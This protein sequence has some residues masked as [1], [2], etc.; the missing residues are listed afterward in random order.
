[1]AA[2][3]R[4]TRGSRAS[5]MRQEQADETGSNGHRG[6][7][8]VWA[9]WHRGSCFGNHN[10]G[11]QSHG[12]Q[13][14]WDTAALGHSVSQGHGIFVLDSQGCSNCISMVLLPQL[15]G[16]G[17]G[18]QPV[19]GAGPRGCSW[20]PALSGCQPHPLPGLSLTSPPLASPPSP[21][22]PPW[23]LPAWLLLRSS[24]AQVKPTP[25]CAG[26]PRTP[27][28]PHPPGAT[29]PG[30][31]PGRAPSP[32]VVGAAAASAREQVHFLEPCSCCAA[33]LAHACCQ[34]RGRATA[35]GTGH[36]ALPAA[37]GHGR[38]PKAGSCL[39]PGHLAPAAGPCPQGASW[40]PAGPCCDVSTRPLLCSLVQE[41]PPCA[42]RASGVAAVAQGRRVTH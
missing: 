12:A 34:H 28:P 2:V 21:A 16:R 6:C 41:P 30:P 23:P 5:H 4:A 15:R 11:H 3:D 32:T 20:M 14:P 35:P 13:Q 42:C 26:A 40:L 18:M 24:G 27:C 25:H 36:G 37:L 1:M 8:Q 29:L 17:T 19:L 7:S 22:P 39:L 9:G 10:W 38:V 33:M 31:G